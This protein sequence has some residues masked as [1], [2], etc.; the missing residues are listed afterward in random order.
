MATAIDI[1]ATA[2]GSRRRRRWSG[3]RSI[4]RDDRI[5][6]KAAQ[7]QNKMPWREWRPRAVARYCARC[8]NGRERMLASL[9]AALQRSARFESQIADR[10]GVLVGQRLPLER[11]SCLLLGAARPDPC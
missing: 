9:T 7:E 3:W 10:S 2:I 5:H 1:A 4:T 8:V 6:T 11:K